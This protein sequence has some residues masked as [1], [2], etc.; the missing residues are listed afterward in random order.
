MSRTSRPIYLRT[1][2][3]AGDAGDTTARVPV[4]TA[5]QLEP[6]RWEAVAAERKGGDRGRPGWRRGP[7]HEAA[8]LSRSPEVLR[9]ALRALPGHRLEL[10]VGLLSCCLASG[11]RVQ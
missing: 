1:S 7:S 2:D 10:R 11:G 4:A 5:R 3:V 8:G 6:V 9:I